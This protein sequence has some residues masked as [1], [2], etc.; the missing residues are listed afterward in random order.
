MTRDRRS[1]STLATAAAAGAR[2]LKYVAIGLL[3]LFFVSGITSI[4]PH[5][6]GLVIR[7]GRLDGTT[8]T[9]AIRQP[10][11]LLA[12]PFPIEKVLR[13]PVKLEGQIVI[14]DL[15]RP[16]S[17]AEGSDRIDPLTEGYCLTGDEYLL[18]A[19]LVV[20]YRVSDPVRSQ[21]E[22]DAPEAILKDMA[23]A[24]TIQ[25]TAD[26]GIDEAWRRHR[27]IA[28]GDTVSLERTVEAALNERLTRL[29]I[30]LDV[31]AVE[32]Q[33]IHPPRHLRGDFADV[34]NATAESQQ[35]LDQAT[36]EAAALRL[37]GEAERARLIQESRAERER[38]L[39]R[40]TAEV[41]VVKDL[42]DEYRADPDFVRQRLRLE[43][44]ADVQQQGLRQKVVPAGKSWRV[45]I[46]DWEAGQ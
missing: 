34:Q 19:K 24:S 20:K 46:S 14:D 33:E 1:D 32:I 31:T 15:W 30:G 4:G 38:L 40:A 8:S 17:D 6:I 23:I 3:L 29:R 16:L 28:A 39:A 26:W 12:W 2:M 25:S 18:Q 22:V 41:T 13:V 7:L 11:L 36:G 44:L 37:S 5:E 10:G 42:L 35:V 45:M 43:A 9:A 21:L 27:K